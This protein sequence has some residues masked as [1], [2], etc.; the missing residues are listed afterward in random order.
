MQK[1]ERVDA[2][3]CCLKVLKVLS[4]GWHQNCHALRRN[5]HTTTFDDD[6]AVSYDIVGAFKYVWHRYM[7]PEVI[8]VQC[9]HAMV[10]VIGSALDT[11]EY[12]LCK[13][14]DLP[15]RRKLEALEFVVQTRKIITGGK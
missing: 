15:T 3:F 2:N 9:K 10:Q 8:Q 4:N 5:G 13:W 6:N 1:S 11:W 7:V 12:D 14:N